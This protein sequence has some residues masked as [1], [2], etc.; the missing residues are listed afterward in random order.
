MYI[1][2]FIYL[3]IYA[4]THTHTHT[5]KSYIFWDIT[6]CSPLKVSRRFGGT[7]LIHHH[8]QRISQARNLREAGSKLNIPEHRTLH[9]HRCGNLRSYIHII[10]SEAEIAVNMLR[11]EP[12][13]CV[14]MLLVYTSC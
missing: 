4:Y 8:G 9:N 3:F 14:I 11:N 2:I 13:T 12:L 6:P 5:H 10:Y 7:Y 1:Y